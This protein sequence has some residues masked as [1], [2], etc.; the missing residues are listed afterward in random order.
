M[1]KQAQL[2]SVKADSQISFQISCPLLSFLEALTMHETCFFFILLPLLEKHEVCV[3]GGA[4]V[5][6]FKVFGVISE[7]K[8]NLKVPFSPLMLRSQGW[9]GC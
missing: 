5:A 6:G 3:C 9:F 4:G 2:P 1:R 8:A 7:T